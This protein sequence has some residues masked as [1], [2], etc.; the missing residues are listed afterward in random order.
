MSSTL[1]VGSGAQASVFMQQFKYG[2]RRN[3]CIKEFTSTGPYSVE[4]AVLTRL[5][6]QPHV[7]QIVEVSEGFVK[8]T[9]FKLQIFME[10]YTHGDLFNFILKSA[11]KRKDPIN[12]EIFVH[13]LL[14]LR[15]MHSIGIA[16]RDIKPEN[17]FISEDFKITIGDF[18]M[19]INVNP[20]N[21]LASGMMGTGCYQAPEVRS[22]RYS[23]AP[24]DAFKSDIWS[25]GCVLFCILFG[26]LPFLSLNEHD[27]Y[28]TMITTGNWQNFWREHESHAEI[29]LD[30]RW[31]AILAR[32]LAVAPQ[33]RSTVAD[34]LDDEW[35]RAD[36]ISEEDWISQMTELFQD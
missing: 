6:D 10:Y 1:P 18:G 5:K 20:D 31:K 19:S 13:I 27:I 14:G 15:S 16:H 7:C 33:E 32:M 30:N 26:H 2:P 3:V 21:P 35:L 23:L 11:R 8:K 29:T 34:L 17:I 28:L 4:K 25:L 9:P 12:K 22:T 24:Y 36:Q